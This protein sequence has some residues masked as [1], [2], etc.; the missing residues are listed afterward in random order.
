MLFIIIIIFH[1]LIM[2]QTKKVEVKIKQKN[3]HV[4]KYKLH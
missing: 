1:H 2:S 4:E 3:Q